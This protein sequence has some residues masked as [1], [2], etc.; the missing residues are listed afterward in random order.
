MDAPEL[1][2][3]SQAA[4][5]LSATSQTI[6]NWIRSGRLPAVRIGNRFLIPPEEV[7]RLRGDLSPATG[8]SPWDYSA[9]EPAEPLP[10]K[11]AARQPSADPADG[12]LGA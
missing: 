6:R 10:R 8:E 12:L 4:E 1:L 7:A 2:T 5:A 11:A 3:V 9:D